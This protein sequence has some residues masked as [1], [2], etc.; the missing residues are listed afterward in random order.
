MI[1]YNTLGEL[2]ISYRSY[3]KL[4]QIDFATIIN[5]DK[6]TIQRW[7]NNHSLIKPE[8][9]KSIVLE[10]LM[11]YQL[12]NNLNA[13]VAIPTFYNFKTRKYSLDKRNKHLPRAL[14]LKDEIDIKTVNLRTIDLDIDRKYINQFMSS[15]MRKV[16]YYNADLIKTAVE[17]LPELNFISNSKLGYYTGH[18][19][20]LPLKAAVY[21][22]LKNKELTNKDIRATDLTNYKLLEK[23]IFYEYDVYGDCNDT[24]FYLAAHYY[25]FFRDTKNKNYICGGYT[26]SEDV[27]S[28]DLELGMDIIWEDTELQKDLDLKVPPRFVEGNFNNFLA[29]SSSKK[30]RVN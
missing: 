21:E 2:L 24:I 3:N 13:E 12:L 6:R 26:E 25:R 19:I 7:E 10:S 4:S 18:C 23:P 16:G 22:K 20:I 9:I 1:K 5:V 11:P 8:K 27:Y 28:L 14:W 30:T 17:L 29:S 15:Q